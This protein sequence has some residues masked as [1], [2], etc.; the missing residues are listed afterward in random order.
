MKPFHPEIT[1]ET[2]EKL[3]SFLPEIAGEMTEKLKPFLPEIA[4]EM[5]I[6][7]NPFLPEISRGK[8]QNIPT[9]FKIENR[10]VSQLNLRLKISWY[11]N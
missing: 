7:M 5:T 4:G 6:K 9:E 1:G 8:R 10:L 2:T 11:P 3:K